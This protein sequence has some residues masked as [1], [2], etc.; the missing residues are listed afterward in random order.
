MGLAQLLTC[1]QHKQSKVVIAGKKKIENA[2]RQTAPKSTPNIPSF[3]SVRFIF[4]SS[5]IHRGVGRMC[6]RSRQNCLFLNVKGGLFE[7]IVPSLPTPLIHKRNHSFFHHSPAMP[8]G[9]YERMHQIALSNLIGILTC[10]GNHRNNLQ[11]TKHLIFEEYRKEEFQ[12]GNSLYFLAPKP[13][14]EIFYF[15][16]LQNER[17]SKVLECILFCSTH[18]LQFPVLHLAALHLHVYLQQTNDFGV[19]FMAILLFH[20][21]IDF[22][23]I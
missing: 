19:F 13:N 3:K 17:I 10:N 7:P 2:R 22:K 9:V 4:N 21:K 5:S 8:L 1:P 12:A 20:P 6:K 18:F 15:Q 23:L 16:I 11:T 14:S